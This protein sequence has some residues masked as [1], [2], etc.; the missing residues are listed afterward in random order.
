MKFVV[1]IMATV[2]FLVLVITIHYRGFGKIRMRWQ[3]AGIDFVPLAESLA[4]VLYAYWALHF[5]WGDSSSYLYL[6]FGLT[7]LI[8][9]LPLML[10]LKDFISGLS[11]RADTKVRP[12]L[13]VEI[14]K[15]KGEIEKLGLSRIFLKSNDDSRITIPYSRIRSFSYQSSKVEET[16][17]LYCFQIEVSDVDKSDEALDII[18]QMV[19]TSPWLPAG[20]T[21]VI[22][23]VEKPGEHLAVEVRIHAL[24]PEHAGLIEKKLN[25]KFG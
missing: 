25:E 2:I 6:V 19:L 12:G 4:A 7:L 22:R 1:F 23:L 24:S 14:N 15:E 11:Y 9:G 13:H 18:R 10:V 16:A 17:D 3:G 8:I 20:T 21:P 5:I